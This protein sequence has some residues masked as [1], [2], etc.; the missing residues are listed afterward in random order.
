[1]HVF[2]R[3]LGHIQ[4]QVDGREIP[5]ALDARTHQSLCR[6][7]CVNLGQ[8]QNGDLG[9]QLLHHPI[10]LTAGIHRHACDL[11]P[12]QQRVGVEGSHQP[13]AVLG[14]VEVGHQRL[15]QVARAHNN[16]RAFPV[17]AH[18]PSDGGTQ[19]RYVISVTLL[20]KPA[21]TIEILAH[22]R[23]G[24]S[25]TFSQCTGRD[26]GDPCILQIA[27]MPEVPG[28][29]MD[30]RR[31]DLLFHGSSSLGKLVLLIVSIVKLFFQECKY[32]L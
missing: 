3:H 15:A 27:Q 19:L 1:M 22:L 11:C 28:H 4:M 13:H 26:P 21:E 17:D 30:H 6:R 31:R 16:G 24:Q 14:E 7:P 8:G 10:Q 20:P 23:G 25:H 29:P 9:L 32:S 12:D 2:H 18:D 5:D